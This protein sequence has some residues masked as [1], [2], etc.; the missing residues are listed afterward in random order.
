MTTTLVRNPELKPSRALIFMTGRNCEMYV[1]DAIASV[2][3]QTHDAVHVLFIDDASDDATAEIAARMLNELFEGRHTY[4]RNESQFGKARNAHVHLRAALSEGDFVGVLDADDQLIDVTVLSQMANAYVSGFDVVWT[5]FVTDGGGVGQNGPLDPLA[6]P[7]GQGWITSHFFSFRAELLENVPESYFQDAR[8]QWFAAACDLALAFPVLDQTRRYCYLPIKAYRYTASNLNSQH[9]MD[10]QAHGLSS[11]LQ[12]AN[13]AQVLAKPPLPCKRFVFGE[14]PSGDQA[15]AQ[16]RERM[17]R[18][19]QLV[20]A[21]IE[22]VTAALPKHI[23]ES[24][25]L[26]SGAQGWV[27]AAANQLAERCPRLLD[28][29]LDGHQAEELGVERAWQL[30]RWLSGGSKAPNLLEIG[31]GPMAAPVLAMVQSLGGRTVSAAG[32]RPRAEALYARLYASGLEPNVVFAPHV[33]AAFEGIEGR[34]PN[35]GSLSGD[36]GNFDVVFVSAAE[37]GE[38]PAHAT[39]ALPAV[40]SRLAAGARLCLWAPDHDALRRDTLAVWRRVADDLHY[41]DHAFG[42]VALCVMSE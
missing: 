23:A 21:S 40:A 17:L 34:F 41:H 1:A 20:S 33:D 39:L 16:L 9:N 36:L 4:V 19:A 27:M 11:R 10:P 26:S 18:Q 31:A 8:G 37:A 29:M 22:Q 32:D 13:A 28:L 3:R 2:A 14:H 24:G 38:Q 25:K 7:R 42:G 5:N 6:S 12:Q 15:Y 35:L 30:F